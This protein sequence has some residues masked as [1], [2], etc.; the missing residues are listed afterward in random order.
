MRRVNIVSN[1]YGRGDLAS[2]KYQAKDTCFIDL[3]DERQRSELSDIIWCSRDGF[4]ETLH[5]LRCIYA[6][7]D[8]TFGLAV[9]WSIEIDSISSSVEKSRLGHRCSGDRAVIQKDVGGG[10]ECNSVGTGIDPGIS[11]GKVEGSDCG[12]RESE[13]LKSL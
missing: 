3:L 9:D 13:C 8:Y 1:D 5:G 6:V 10:S 12:I 2:S 4:G 11:K 7:P